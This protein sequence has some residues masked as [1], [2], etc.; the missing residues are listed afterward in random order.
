MTQ[1]VLIIFQTIIN[2]GAQLF[3]KKGVSGVSFDQPIIKL[4]LALLFNPYIFA[5]GCLFVISFLSWLY[6]LSKFDLSF[7]Y[8]I[9]SLSFVTTA[10]VGWFFLAETISFNRGIGITLIMIG[11]FFIAKS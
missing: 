10:L 9:S 6:L 1:Y 11:V 3:L 8:P 5:G 7:L 2:T 4:F